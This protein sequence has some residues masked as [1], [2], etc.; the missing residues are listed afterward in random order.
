[1][2]NLFSLFAL[3]IPILAVVGGITIAIVR[4]IAQGRIEELVRRERIAAIERGVDPSKLPPLPAGGSDLYGWHPSGPLRRGQGLIIGG[5]ILVA[6]GI[7]LVIILLT[8]EPHKSHWVIGTLPMLVGLAL[9]ASAAIIW[10]R[11]P[12]S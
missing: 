8:V 1:M 5:L 10:P 3:A 7:G 9:L 6:V 4:I 2:E 12:K 11:R